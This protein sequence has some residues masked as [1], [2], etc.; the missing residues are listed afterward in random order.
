V[1]TRRAFRNGRYG[2]AIVA[3]LL[4]A[5][6]F[7]NG[8]VAGFAW[9]APGLVLF[10]AA[11]LKGGGAFRVGYV[12]GLASYLASLYWLL[13]I[14]VTGGLVFAKALGWIALSAYLALYPATWV[15]LCWKMFPVKWEEPFSVKLWAEK[16]LAAGWSRRLAWTL[17][18][19]ALWVALEMTVARLLG[20]FPWLLLGDSQYRIV[21]VIQ[22]ASVTG[23]YGVSFLLVWFSLS[24]MSAMVSLARGGAGRAMLF[25]EI[26]LPMLAAAVIFACGYAKVLKPEPKGRELK[27]ALVQPSIPQTVKWDENEN[28]RSFAGVIKLSEG[29]LTNKPD[30]LIWPES[31]VP[32]MV[33]WDEETHEAVCGLAR[34]NHVWMIIGSDDF[35]PHPG[36][37]TFKDGDYYNSSFLV[38]PDGKLAASYRKRRLV[39]FGE[40]VPLVKWL[41]FLKYLTPIEGGFVPGERAVSF[42]MPNLKAKASVLI[43]YEDVF[44]HSPA[45]ESGDDPDFVVNLTNDGW[46]GEGAEQWQ[47]AAAGVFRAVE[48]G[49]PLVRCCNNGLTCWIDPQGRMRQIFVGAKNGIYGP[50]FLIAHI[51][52]LP[53]GQKNA[54]TFY[55]LHGDW[56]GWACMGWA[57][58][59]F[60][61]RRKT[62]YRAA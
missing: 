27:V 10:T 11:G 7:P 6:A 20:G 22:I 53:S 3:G 4:L 33:K 42:D 44:P 54:P 57:V 15:W 41:P 30:L 9:V 47:H 23:V 31:A 14:P 58:L 55:H 32:R 51:P 29:A 18:G 52:I 62:F 16:F 39:I 34:S 5:A 36:A 38:S 60:A 59:Q 43:C 50:G 26:I 1:E 46:F 17:S 21:P 56:F 35:E 13:L 45:K 12:A 40:Y 37:K 19:A 25:A 61:I 2:A 49:L 24:L 8:N 48:N 28:A